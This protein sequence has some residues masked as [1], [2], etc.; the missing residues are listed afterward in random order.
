M[1]E[2]KIGE[3]LAYKDGGSTAK[4]TAIL[5][6]RVEKEKDPKFRYI[7]VKKM[8]SI[9]SAEELRYMQ[10]DYYDFDVIMVNAAKSFMERK[11]HIIISWLFD[12]PGDTPI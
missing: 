8:Y 11:P 1:S 6:V 7:R 5:I 4:S 3:W 10:K 9:G 12:G 2:V